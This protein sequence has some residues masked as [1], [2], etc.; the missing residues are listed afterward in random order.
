MPQFQAFPMQQQDSASTGQR[1]HSH[2]AFLSIIVTDTSEEKPGHLFP[3]FQASHAEQAPLT[4]RWHLWMP[5]KMGHCLGF[6]PLFPTYF[7]SLYLSASELGW[8]TDWTA[9]ALCRPYP[10]SMRL[11]GFPSPDCNSLKT[12]FLSFWKLSLI[13]WGRGRGNLHLWTQ[14]LIW[15]RNDPT[16]TGVG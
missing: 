12:F 14:W 15:D 13:P 4:L 10:H 3:V 11:E 7:P 16:S 9:F 5:H 1:F 2:R 8:A 6:C